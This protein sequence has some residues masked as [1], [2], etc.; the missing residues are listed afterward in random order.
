[1]AK[2]LMVNNPKGK[3]KKKKKKSGSKKTKYKSKSKSKKK[4]S[5]K[6]K[7]ST[8]QE[9]KTMA[10]KK[11]KS[12]SKS[13]SVAKTK[14]KSKKRTKRRPS[15]SEIKRI[16]KDAVIPAFIG[17]GSAVLLNMGISKLPLPPVLRS[18][19]GRLLIKGA[20]SIGGGMALQSMVD[21]KIGHSFMIGGLT[22]LAADLTKMM[23]SRAFP[24][25]QLGDYY[26]DGEMEFDM[27][28]NEYMGEFV[29]DD[30]GD[31]MG[32]IMSDYADDDLE[33]VDFVEGEVVYD[34]F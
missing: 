16:I 28:V 20:A 3:K 32:Q 31:D 22:L 26:D 1:M 27:E 33:A 4:L 18:G 30:V 25:A 34:E 23:I 2:L 12:K 24:N 11:S 10:K 15:T 7:K 21:K 5:V 9:E 6:R 19:P 13:K 14:S 29:S 17:G 8:G